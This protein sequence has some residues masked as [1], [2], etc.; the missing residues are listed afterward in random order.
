MKRKT[1]ARHKVTRNGKTFWRG[2]GSASSIPQKHR[3]R[4]AIVA[5]MEQLSSMYEMDNISQAKHDR[6]HKKLKMELGNVGKNGYDNLAQK[7]KGKVMK[8]LYT[9]T[10]SKSDRRL[11]K[12]NSRTAS[13]KELRKRNLL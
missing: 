9:G 12:S 11:E 7:T 6:E 2:K 8:R 4:E 13:T 5:D 1:P 3:S 10:K